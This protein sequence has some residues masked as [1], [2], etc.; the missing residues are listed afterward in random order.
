MIIPDGTV[1]SLPPP[2]PA[3]GSWLRRALAGTD[4]QTAQ[5]PEARAF[6]W[7]NREGDVPRHRLSGEDIAAIEASLSRGGLWAI[8]GYRTCPFCPRQGIGPTR[9]ASDS[10]EW[11][12]GDRSVAVADD[13]GRLWVGPDLVLHYATEHGYGPGF[14]MRP[15][16][17]ALV[18]ALDRRCPEL[19]LLA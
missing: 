15:A 2:Q 10:C 9:Y 4:P 16:P 8:R 11:H 17:T 1:L 14:A 13:E 7:L 6:G 5:A 19:V 3:P 12:L 18:R